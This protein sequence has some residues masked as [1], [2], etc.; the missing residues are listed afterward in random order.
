MLFNSYIFVLAFLPMTVAA[1]FWLSRVSRQAGLAWLIA[2]SFFFYAWWDPRLLPLLLGSIA[3]NH[4][5]WQAIARTAGRMQTTL[6]VSGIAANLG[7]LA[8]FKYAAA[9]LGATGIFISQPVLPLGISFFT[10]TQIALLV[11]AP[12]RPRATTHTDRA[13]LVC[14]VLPAPDRRPRAA[15]SGR[16]AAILGRDDIS[17]LS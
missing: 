12:S 15:P 11:D 4:L 14:V 9:W 5:L 1:F 16:D 3:V 6:L 10:F 8:W 2:A 13:R 7:A 17:D